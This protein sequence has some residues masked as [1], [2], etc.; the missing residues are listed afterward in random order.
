MHKPPYGYFEP[1]EFGQHS[2]LRTYLIA[3]AAEFVDTYMYLLP[4][5]D[6]GQCHRLI[7]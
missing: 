5:I 6:E 1:S 4:R 3:A 2:K 7:F